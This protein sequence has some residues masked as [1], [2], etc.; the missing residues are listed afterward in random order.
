MFLLW[1]SSHIHTVSYSFSSVAQNVITGT[2]Q[3]I[4]CLW[5]CVLF[6]MCLL[7]VYDVM[8]L[9]PLCTLS[10]RQSLISELSAL[11]L[12][13]FSSG[14]TLMDLQRHLEAVWADLTL[15]PDP[16]TPPMVQSTQGQDGTC[17]KGGGQQHPLPAA[18]VLTCVSRPGERLACANVWR[19]S[20]R[21]G[22]SYEGRVYLKSEREERERGSS[23]QTPGSHWTVSVPDGWS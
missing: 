3:V 21:R 15:D 5:K 8:V 2:G 6:F 12:Q 20:F 22:E 17:D 14:F 7:S 10:G 9:S 19:I 16:P 18:A 11:L 23:M 1:I 13:H 4:F